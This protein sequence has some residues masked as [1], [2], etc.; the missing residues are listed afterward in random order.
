MTPTDEDVDTQAAIRKRAHAQ[1]L[2]GPQA[3]AM[4][5]LNAQIPGTAND[6][7]NAIL[8]YPNKF[9]ASDCKF[10]CMG[11][12]QGQSPGSLVW[13][14]IRGP[15]STF[16]H[17]V[18]HNIGGLPDLYLSSDPQADDMVTKESATAIYINQENVPP[19]R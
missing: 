18:G 15:M 19:R 8:I 6:Y 1:I 2:W 10:G 14:R 5:S 7:T 11:P 4:N 16:A 13:T 9:V 17:E 12:G 3:E